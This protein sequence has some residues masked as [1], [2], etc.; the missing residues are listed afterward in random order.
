MPFSSSSETV[1]GNTFP[2]WKRITIVLLSEV[3][4]LAAVG[5]T[6][7]VI[8]GLLPSL[9]HSAVVVLHWVGVTAEIVILCLG[10]AIAV[11]E[12]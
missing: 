2:F 1:A 5:I 4:A 8:P 11:G 10:I 9:S 6:V 7:S 12:T 3:L